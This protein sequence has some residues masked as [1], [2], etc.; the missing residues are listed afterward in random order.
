MIDGNRD[1]L[2]ETFRWALAESHDPAAAS[3]DWL[4]HDVDADYGSAIEMLSDSS[5]PL[6]TLRRAKNAFKTMRIVGETTADRRMG[7]RLY[8]GTIAAGLVHHGH[9]ISRQSDTALRRA[10]TALNDDPEMHEQ[11]RCLAGTALCLLGGQSEGATEDSDFW[12]DQDES[13]PDSL[14]MPE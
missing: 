6:R 4:A 9:R 7:G 14:P 13:D 12:D 5:V 3:A 11:L 1:T 2:G 10:L 8:L